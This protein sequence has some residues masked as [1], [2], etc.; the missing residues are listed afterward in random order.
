MQRKQ[1]ML[2]WQIT[3]CGVSTI[4]QSDTIAGH[5]TA[6]HSAISGWLN[7]RLLWISTGSDRLEAERGSPDQP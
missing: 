4:R 2:L 7:V 5:Y 1:Q 3:G 6:M